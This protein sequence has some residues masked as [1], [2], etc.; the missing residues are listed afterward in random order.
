[1]MLNHN[2][3]IFY[4]GTFDESVSNLYTQSGKERYIVM[5]ASRTDQIRLR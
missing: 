4:T 5:H 1:M 3:K 2:G